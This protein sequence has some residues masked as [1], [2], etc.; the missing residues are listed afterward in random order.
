M[1][2][3]SSYA[4][5]VQNVAQSFSDNELTLLIYIQQLFILRVVSPVVARAQHDLV[6]SAEAICT[7][8]FGNSECHLSIL[9]WSLY[10]IR[11]V[12][13][14]EV[15]NLTLPK[16]EL[17]FNAANASLDFLEGSF[18]KHAA[19]IMSSKAPNLWW[20]IQALLDSRKPGDL[21][22]E[23]SSGKDDLTPLDDDVEL[24]EIGETNNDSD[25]A[26]KGQK[27]SGRK[28][29]LI[30]IKA[31]VVI[32]ILT[33][34]TN[35]RC[36]YLQAILGIFFHSCSVPEK[37]IETLSH[38]GV[39]IA[40]TTIH[41]AITSLSAKCTENLKRT[42]RT[43]CTMFAYDNFDI[44]FKV[45]H[46]T[47]ENPSTFVSA[48]SA[49]AIPIYGVTDVN[50]DV[51][52]WSRAYWDQSPLNPS[53]NAHPVIFSKDQQVLLRE[54]I[55]KDTAKLPGQLLTQQQCRWAWHVRRIL[56]MDCASFKNYQSDL[57]QPEI[58]LEIPLHRTEQIPCRAMKYKESTNDGNIQ[59][60][61][62]LHRQGGIGEPGEKGFVA[63]YDVDMSEWVILVH[64]DLLT[65]ERIDAVRSTRS[66][67]DTAKA[68][69]QHIIFIPGLFH[70][71]MACAD[72]FWRTWVKPQ[73]CRNDASSFMEHIGIL[74]PDDTKKFGSS[75]GFQMVH[76]AIHYDL[77]ASMLD[78]WRTEAKG[79]LEAFAAHQPSWN[80]LVKMSESII[81]K[82]VAKTADLAGERDKDSSQRDKR[83]ENQTLRNRDELLYVDMSYAMNRG[84]IGCVK[85]SMVPWIHIFKATGK[86]KYATHTLHFL[87][88]LKDRFPSELRLVFIQIA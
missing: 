80:D 24:G 50:K 85:A 35:Q 76:D 31:I 42:V 13:C 56:V 86:H 66:I 21:E 58:I 69:F 29:A 25:P 53:P 63:G 5:R 77:T 52:K 19:S 67:E 88:D 12:L 18:M 46:P 61:D 71:K 47:L 72:A 4:I 20:M 57:G 82:F 79:S 11:D 55:G 48:T 81:Q 84:D 65:K 73:E 16:T 33:H 10:S 62:D 7:A 9:S 43:L 37:V 64:G 83:F 17:N 34:S 30:V 3:A 26:A 74:R 49:T 8:L 68:R 2:E 38:A 87:K 78:C 40:L 28:Q 70:Y 75:P 14:A 36:N 23:K 60:L 15:M 51:L 27:D 6:S 44:K 41:H 39:C 59:V 32:S 22:T 45:H 54:L 1:S